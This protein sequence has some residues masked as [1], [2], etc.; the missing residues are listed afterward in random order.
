MF[1]N[2]VEYVA[3]SDSRLDSRGI[4]NG[5]DP[6]KL[7]KAER[8]RQ[9]LSGHNYRAWFSRELMDEINSH[10]KEGEEKLL[11]VDIMS[12]LRREQR[13]GKC[14]IRG[15]GSDDGAKPFRRGF[16]IA[17]FDDNVP[18]DMALERAIQLTTEA[19]TREGEKV[20]LMQRIQRISDMVKESRVLGELVS[21]RLIKKELRCTDDE[22]DTS[23]TRAMQIHKFIKEVRISNQRFLHHAEFEKP[24]LDEIVQAKRHYIS[25]RQ[26]YYHRVGHNWES[27]VDWFITRFT[28]AAKFRTQ[29]HRTGADS[30]MDE[31][32]ITVHLLKPVG[33]RRYAAELDRVWNVDTGPYSASITY[34]LEAKW[35]LV[36]KETLDDIIDVLRWSGDYGYD[37]AGGERQVRQGIVVMLAA[38]N[39]NP[40]EMVTLRDGEKLTLQEYAGR[41]NI[42]LVR[43]SHMNEQ[44]RQHGV[45]KSVT[46][47]QICRACR[48]ER[49]VRQLLDQVWAH[50]EQAKELIS[51]TRKRDADIYAAE[52]E[53]EK[54]TLDDGVSEVKEV[55]SPPIPTSPAASPAA[56]LP[57][58]F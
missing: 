47:Q 33:K 58:L 17:W 30:A 42:K 8:I 20:P 57:N 55:Q 6:E 39:F 54:E 1:V 48:N 49:E 21:V 53:L 15:Y 31:R 37:T 27:V 23:I 4:C 11:I 5:K 7:S 36:H 24:V 50:P 38:P 26:G 44:L 9:F 34:I 28:P 16:C 12:T 56:G 22:L 51:E 13:K 43:A 45:D 35:G 25:M 18:H 2:G 29:K 3:F 10:P 46:V 52:A 14:Y 19:L 41:M 32:R 40:A